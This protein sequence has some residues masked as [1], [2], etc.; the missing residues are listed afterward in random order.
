M[1]SESSVSE[2]N[3]IFQLQSK[4]QWLV[5]RSTAEQRI[6]TLERLKSAI[7]SRKEAIRAALYSDLPS[8]CSSQSKI[9]FS[10][11]LILSQEF[12]KLI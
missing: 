5:K 2:I 7:Q 3:R 8:V 4:H 12:A 11:T 1:N 9:S 6:A 10:Q